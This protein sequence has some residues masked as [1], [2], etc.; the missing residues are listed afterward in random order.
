MTSLTVRLAGL[1]VAIV[2][3]A[4]AIVYLY[5]V[6]PLTNK[7]HDEE[8]KT[9][10]QQVRRYAPPL[11][12]AV[13]TDVDVKVVDRLVRRTAA[14]SGLRVTL[15]GVNQ[16]A[17]GLQATP[18]SDS[19]TQVAIRDLQFAT[20]VRAAQARRV[21]TGSEAG[22]AGRVGEAAI[23]LFYRDKSGKRAVG[24]ALVLSKT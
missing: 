12:R 7:L 21:A 17:G 2:A 24:F 8:L 14:N 3:A 10:A 5:A 22:D 15:L 20:A 19:T 18:R 13:A 1:L 16:V 11:Q 6:P 9:L 4:I 23:P